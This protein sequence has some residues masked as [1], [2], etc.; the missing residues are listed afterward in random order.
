MSATLAGVLVA[1][2][3]CAV[4]TWTVFWQ[5]DERQQVELDD[6]AARLAALERERRA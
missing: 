3:V 1:L 2:V 6:H 5:R 4:V